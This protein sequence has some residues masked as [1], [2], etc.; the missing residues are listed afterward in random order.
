MYIQKNLTT[1]TMPIPGLTYE[2][3]PEL[4]AK[5]WQYKAFSKLV[6][7]EDDNLVDIVEDT[8]KRAAFEAEEAANKPDP[9]EEAV[10]DLRLQR[11]KVFRAFDIYKTN[12]YYGIEAETDEQHEAV[13]EWYNSWLDIT[14]G[15]SARS[16]PEIPV[17]PEYIEK[18]VKTGRGR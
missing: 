15:V 13:L 16:T 18:Y 6:F 14:E 5:F 10:N 4:Q 2:L 11:N 17:T 8:E 3:T 7:D 9:V 1:S 12:V